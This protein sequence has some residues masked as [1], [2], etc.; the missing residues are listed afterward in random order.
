MG[1]ADSDLEDV[2]QKLQQGRDM[3][4][5]QQHFLRNYMTRM[6]TM[7]NTPAMGSRLKRLRED[8]Q[9]PPTDVMEDL[10]KAADELIAVWDVSRNR[11]TD[12]PGD[13]MS[14]EV[15]PEYQINV[16]LKEA[17]DVTI[18]QQ[19]VEVH[20]WKKFGRS[21]STGED[22]AYIDE[23][24]ATT[25]KVV[26]TPHA[27]VINMDLGSVRVDR[28][29]DDAIQR[30]VE[31]VVIAKMDW[32]KELG[33]DQELKREKQH[34]VCKLQ[35]EKAKGRQ[36][37]ES[38]KCRMEAEL[39]SLYRTHQAE[40]RKERQKLKRF[41]LQME[42]E[43]GKLLKEVL[44]KIREKNVMSKLVQRLFD[45]FQVRLLGVDSGL[46]FLMDVPVEEWNELQKKARELQKVMEEMLL[47]KREQKGVT[48]TEVT[49]CGPEGGETDLRLGRP[50]PADLKSAT[51][52]GIT[53]CGEEEAISAENSVMFDPTTAIPQRIGKFRPD[54]PGCTDYLG[55]IITS[56]VATEDGRL[57]LADYRTRMVIVAD[58]TN[59][60]TV[61]GVR[62]QDPP[63]RLSLLQDGTLA[64]TSDR[65]SLYLVDV[66]EEPSVAAWVQTSRQYSGVCAGITDDT[67]I[68]SCGKDDG[69]PA[70]VDVISRTG[71]FKRTVVDNSSLEDLCYPSYLHLTGKDVLVSDWKANAV[72]RVDLT[73]SRVVAR[74]T[75]PD[76]DW[77]RQIAADPSGL[78]GVMLVFLFRPDSRII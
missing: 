9:L 30:A 45:D 54:V 78:T 51:P 19:H 39:A 65:K 23:N 70:S 43:K 14:P 75:H 47:R 11:T 77:P 21:H 57:V 71:K 55:P 26:I 6:P 76:M 25:E 15:P 60:D 35:R 50:I 66:H 10:V 74:L 62:L 12:S 31:D 28:I 67:L 16:D 63:R 17:R 2:R 61:R 22:S 40:K 27:T 34:L 52:A 68:V 38:E 64:V 36:Q 5:A 37:L 32:F 18:C 1:Q 42:K 69:R 59:P 73:T 29:T 44:K 56:M 72:F 46:R 3:I 53:E 41:V 58:G 24:D 20:V 4:Q 49:Q 33:R 8:T 48:W 7:V 13:E